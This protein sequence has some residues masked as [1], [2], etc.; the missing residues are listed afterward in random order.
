MMSPIPPSF[1][2]PKP[3]SNQVALSLQSI[4]PCHN[5]H[6]ISLTCTVCLNCSTAS[7]SVTS[8]HHFLRFFF[9]LLP[10][11]VYTTCLQW[12]SQ[13]LEPPT[14]SM[15]ASTS[16]ISTLM[17]RI[18]GAYLRTWSVFIDMAPG[19]WNLRR[20]VARLERMKWISV[21]HQV[22]GGPF[23]SSTTCEMSSPRN[24][25]R[26]PKINNT[27]FS[28]SQRPHLQGFLWLVTFIWH[29]LVIIHAIANCIRW[30]V[31]ISQLS[32]HLGIQGSWAETFL[33]SQI[34]R[35]VA[36]Q[37]PPANL[38]LLRLMQGCKHGKVDISLSLLSVQWV[39]QKYTLP[40]NFVKN[41]IKYTDLKSQAI[42]DD[43]IFF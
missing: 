10:F 33:G 25:N 7:Q 34:F 14:E 36:E 32:I 42:Y 21:K 15:V 20:G 8:I 28:R 6:T 13:F 37:V 3:C 19:E 23:F 22:A 18:R 16:T 1:I 27:A 26:Q 43:Q 12:R 9:F 39:I 17:S 24:T 30:L 4:C 5:C 41:K 40:L 31:G 11:L 2:S 38:L 35:R 29:S